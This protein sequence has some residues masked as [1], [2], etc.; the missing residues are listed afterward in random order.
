MNDELYEKLYSAFEYYLK[1]GRIKANLVHFMPTKEATYPLIILEEIRNTPTYIAKVGRQSA[2]SLG[3][4]F[5]VFAKTV[6]RK[7]HQT[8]ANELVGEI[9]R[10]MWTLNGHPR[11]SKNMIPNPDGNNTLYRVDVVYSLNTYDNGKF[12]Y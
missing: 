5:S 12:V 6:G 1:S 3:Y 4:K 8:I 10:F 9:N 7:T 11:T 2:S